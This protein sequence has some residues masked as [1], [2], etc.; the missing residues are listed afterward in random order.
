MALFR[1]STALYGTGVDATLK[2]ASSIPAHV[3]LEALHIVAH[4]QIQPVCFTH[5]VRIHAD[6][7]YQTFCG[8][9]IVH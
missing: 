3:D 7:W 5:T 6:G 2:S 8:S 9:F 1:D 4:L